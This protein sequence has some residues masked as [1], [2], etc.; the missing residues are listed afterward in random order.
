MPYIDDFGSRVATSKAEALQH[1]DALGAELRWL[2]LTETVHKATPLSQK[3]LWLDLEFD[4][5]RITIK[6]LQPTS[7]LTEVSQQSAAWRDKKAAA[8][9]QLHQL[10]SKLFFIANCF[11]P[12]RFFINHML[13]PSQPLS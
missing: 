11:P 3:M 5:I 6:I 10:L 9:Q 7:K 2:G 13:V 4:T 8:I 1:F 12:T